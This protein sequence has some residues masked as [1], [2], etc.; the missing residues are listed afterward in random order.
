MR[1]LGKRPAIHDPRVP[2]LASLMRA[3]TS[4][5][6]CNWWAAIG[7]WPWCLNDKL[8]T[9]VEAGALHAIQQ[10]LAYVGVSY[11]PTDEETAELYTRW[12]GYQ[13]GDA[14]TDKGT[15][16]SAALADWAKA[17]VTWTTLT[18]YAAIDHVNIAWIKRAIWRCG[19]VLLGLN[20]PQAWLDADYLLDLPNGLGDIAGGHCIY[21]CGYQPTALGD[22][23]TAVTWGG[24]FAMTGRALELVADE[25]YAILS[26]DWFDATGHDPASV[27]WADAETAM[28]ALR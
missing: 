16:M 13:P 10:R 14:N 3:D 5:E 8:G 2:R 6:Q 7:A 15:I 23:F 20:L 19:G 26:R 18:A 17:P 28:A 25:A 24:R 27:A 1:L 4:P 9:C 21:L 11:T 22:E 12:S